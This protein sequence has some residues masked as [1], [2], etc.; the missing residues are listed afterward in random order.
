[1]SLTI[2]NTGI[3]VSTEDRYYIA[4]T[5]T[6]NAVKAVIME[7]YVQGFGSAALHQI[8]HDVDAGTTDTYTF[9][10]NSILRNYFSY[11][12]MPFSSSSRTQ[13]NVLATLLFYEV[14]LAG[15][16]QPPTSGHVINLK[17]MAFDTWES[18]LFN[19]VTG[20]GLDQ[21]NV[22]DTGSTARKFLTSAP[23]NLLVYDYRSIFLS[24]LE[25]S[26]TGS[27]PKQQVQF[28]AYNESNALVSTI[29]VQINPTSRAPIGGSSGKY[30]IFNVRQVMT[31]LGNFARVTAQVVDISGGTVRSELRTF[32]NANFGKSRIRGVVVHWQ[33]EFGVQDSYAFTGEFN[34]IVK[35][36]YKTYE[37]VSVGDTP[38][39]LDFN[40]VYELST[41]HI[42]QDTIIWLT[43]MLRSAK[44]AIEKLDPYASPSAVETVPTYY[45][46]I[47]ETDE[48]SDFSEWNPRNI[49]SI[50][51]RFAKKRR[52]I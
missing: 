3:D 29:N 42:D 44:V 23:N 26:F 6:P 12:F 50:K 25:A 5:N 48:I 8:E 33:N 41:E 37:K 28:K 31:S 39:G 20:F 1:M 27:N 11:S 32:I 24:V 40:Y 21:F 52:G 2:T 10:I 13:L 43:K 19:N 4:T 46:I 45:P 14:D 35:S 49:F 15:V 16:I 9:E 47:L 18:D 30:D 34:R 22:G 51:F 36:D 38:Y 7:V 17:Q